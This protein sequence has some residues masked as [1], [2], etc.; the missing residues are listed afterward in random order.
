MRPGPTL[1]STV[2]A[3]PI[4]TYV[5]DPETP[6]RGVAVFF[7]G[8]GLHAQ[9]PRY[10]AL[11][12]ALGAEGFEVWAWDCPHHGMSSTL[13]SAAHPLAPLRLPSA[14]NLVVD[15]I[16]LIRLARR[17]NV[18]CVLVGE[19]MGATL[20]MRLATLVHPDGLC[21]IAGGVV[22][23]VSWL[24]G[25]CR[26][27]I[28]VWRSPRASYEDAKRDPLV[29]VGVVPPSVGR[30]MDTVARRTEWA[31]IS[32]PVLLSVGTRDPIATVPDALRTLARCTGA[33]VLRRSIHIVKGARHDNLV[34]VVPE[35][36]GSFCADVTTRV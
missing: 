26:M 19:S 33:P 21:C 35:T 5:Y 32:C 18:P 24:S 4:A 12:R 13:G 10:D 22:S 2:H 8:F 30:T 1:T 36:V 7:H 20:A 25:M 23:R 17:D 29:R 16:Q 27:A 34:E 3:A 9:M 28:V 11:Y 14:R 15:A 31:S 6:V